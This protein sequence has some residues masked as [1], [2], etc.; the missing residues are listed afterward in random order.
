MDKKKTGIIVGVILLIV[1]VV[2]LVLFSSKNDVQFD[3]KGGSEIASQEVKFFKKAN[4]PETPT[5][6]GYTFDNWYYDGE[7]FNFDTKITKDMIIEAR[8]IG[9]GEPSE[10]D[11]D[12]Y[13]ITFNSGEGSKVASQ[14]VK[15]DGTID[16]PDEPTREGYKFVEWQ[17]KGKKWDFK[18]KVT[19]NMTLTAK[20]EKDSS[21][22]A[23]TTFKINS[24]NITLTNGK[25][26]K[27]STK[28]ADGSVTWTS[29]NTKVA[30]VDKNGNIK[31]V[32]VGTATITA[33]DSSGKT[34]SIKVTVKA[35]TASKP[36]GGNTNTPSGG[37][38]G[39]NTGT[40]PEPQPEEP[41]KPEVTYKAVCTTVQGDQA[42]RCKIAIQASDGS[43]VSGVVKVTTADGGGNKNTGDLVRE[44]II[45]GL[46]VVSVNK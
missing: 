26:K 30:T 3:S 2:L 1:V 46:E 17:Y 38:Q 31:A 28:N 45:T 42:G 20:W 24:G 34:S 27:V 10:D 33:K 4:R 8:W 29:S 6:E 16:E 40:T 41:T 5:R 21:A 43:T 9:E 23:D 22:T 32:G 39:G 12:T 14:K 36:N 19:A 35:P 11:G 7:V 15:K 18:D 13:T 44:S 25:S 37:N